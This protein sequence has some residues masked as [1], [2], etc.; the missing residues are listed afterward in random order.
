[1]S[2]NKRSTRADRSHSRL[3]ARATEYIIRSEAYDNYSVTASNPV[4]QYLNQPRAQGLLGDLPLAVSEDIS[5]IAA[6]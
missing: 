4:A 5:Q 6:V 2:L 3:P 1:M